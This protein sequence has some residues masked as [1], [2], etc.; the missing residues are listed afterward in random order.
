MKLILVSIMHA[1]KR[2]DLADP[3]SKAIGFGTASAYAS[4]LGGDQFAISTFPGCGQGV[5][6]K[7]ARRAESR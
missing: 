1:A 7:R 4:M 2:G 5:A 3:D 6:R